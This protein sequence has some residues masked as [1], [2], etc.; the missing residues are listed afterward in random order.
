M[1]DWKAVIGAVAPTMAT[2]LGGP[3]AGMAVKALSLGLLGKEDANLNEVATAVVSGNADVLEKIKQIDAQLQVRMRELD[4]DLARLEV[5]DRKSARE[6]EAATSDPTT[7][8]LAY[9]FVIIYF[10]VIWAVWKFPIDPNVNDLLMILIGILTGA[11]TQILNYYF[12][13]SSGSAQ[14]SNVL[15]KIARN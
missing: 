12:G 13:S 2:M 10:L 11:L 4:I 15:A 5:D 14:K 3:L 7:R 9:M 8:I 6:R 1:A